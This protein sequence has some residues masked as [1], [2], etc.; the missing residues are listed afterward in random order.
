MNELATRYLSQCKENYYNGIRPS[1]KRS[2]QEVG[3]EAL[4]EIAKDYFMKGEIEKFA[5]FFQEYQ[6]SVNLW[7]AHLII[8]YGNPNKKIKGDAFEIIKRYS[9]TPL[10]V[11]LAKE[12]MAWLLENDSKMNNDI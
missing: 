11:E 9:I 4:V 7:T 10:N 12:E 6:Y 2:Y 3:Y 5:K 1:N 8:E